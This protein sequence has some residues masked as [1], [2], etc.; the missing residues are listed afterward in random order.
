MMDKELL[1]PLSGFRDYLG[2]T[3]VRIIRALQETFEQYGYQALETPALERQEIL[4]GKLG[5]EGQKQLYLFEDNGKRKVGLRYDLTVPLARFVSSNLGNIP[6]PFKRYEIGNAWRAEKAQK[7]R[8]RQF[9]QADIDVVGAPEPS[10]EIE[11]FSLVAAVAKKLGLK[12]IYQVSD[13]RVL[14][15][16]MEALKIPEGERMPLM[17]LLD[18]KDKISSEDFNAELVKLGLSDIERRQIASTFLNERADIEKIEKLTGKPELFN[19]VR[20]LLDW[21]KN[22]GVEAEFTPGMVRGLDYYTGTIFEIKAPEYDGG[23]VVAGGRFDSLVE[24]LTGQKIPAV[25]ISFGVDR[26]ADLLQDKEQNETL[27]IVRLPET[28][29]ELDNW[30]RQLRADGK[31]VEVYLDENVE[32]GKQIKYADKRGYQNILIP[33]ENE[34]ARGQIV[35]KNLKS[36][37]QESI[38]RDKI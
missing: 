34:W 9:T 16:I 19:T 17:R 21:A 18:K 25:G 29:N 13:R 22:E 1:Q 36:G 10:S 37:D 11:L 27:Y 14:A 4:L 5:E 15:E 2:P 28:A 30:V 38:N 3:K 35:R 8:F 7:G 31:D 24:Q 20:A 23:T 26:L 33:F 6:L 32:L 12:I